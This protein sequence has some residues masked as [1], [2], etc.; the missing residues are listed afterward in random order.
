VA[1]YV[2]NTATKKGKRVQTERICEN[3]ILVM[4][5]ADIEKHMPNIIRSFF[6]NAGKNV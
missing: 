3:F 2:Y 1:D 5:D 6:G 4:P